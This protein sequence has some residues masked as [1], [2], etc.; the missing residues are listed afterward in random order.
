M[1]QGSVLCVCGGGVYYQQLDLSDP[2]VAEAAL[3]IQA[4]MKGMLFR[5]RQ[6]LA[7]AD[8]TD[9]I[10]TVE[11]EDVP[12]TAEESR[13]SM[14][15]GQSKTSEHLEPGSHHSK[16]SDKGSHTSGLSGQ[17]KTSAHSG[18]GDQERH[19]S[20]QKDAEVQEEGEEDE[21]QQQQQPEEEPQ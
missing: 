15:S 12:D 6:S 14:L 19:T 7:D 16:A 8:S 11:E 21:E 2:E 10:A 18:Q 20:V 17:S 3:K 5:Q 4:A 1:D 13:A 9:H